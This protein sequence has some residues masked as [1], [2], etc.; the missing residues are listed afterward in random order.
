MPKNKYQ[1][2]Y[3]IKNK[4]KITAYN[5]KYYQE[6]KQECID[7]SKKYYEENRTHYR[8][9]G[10]H[11]LWRSLGA[12][13]KLNNQY[14]KLSYKYRF[15]QF[16]L[17]PI[18]NLSCKEEVYDLMTRLIEHPALTVNQRN[19]LVM[20]RDGYTMGEVANLTN[21]N[22]TTINKALN[23]SQYYKD[24]KKEICFYGGVFKK[25]VHI[26]IN[27]HPKDE[28]LKIL[29]EQLKNNANYTNSKIYNKKTTI[30]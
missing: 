23:G 14:K 18:A 25:V 3:Y 13:P 20:L 10:S 4:E 29:I 19:I 9:N 21:R 6:N 12:E 1:K 15:Y 8:L 17:A 22:Q 5:K 7:Y 26:I 30:S 2:S 16:F 27:F 28:S 24:D 11:W